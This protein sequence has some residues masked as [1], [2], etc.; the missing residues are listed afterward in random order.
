MYGFN[1]DSD[2]ARATPGGESESFSRNELM[3][4]SF[5]RVFPAAEGEMLLPFSR[6]TFE[7]VDFVLG[8]G[9]A[10]PESSSFQSGACT[11]RSEVLVEKDALDASGCEEE[12]RR[13]LHPSEIESPP[14][15]P[16]AS[17]TRLSHFSAC[18]ENPTEGHRGFVELGVAVGS[19]PLVL[20]GVPAL[21]PCSRSHSYELHD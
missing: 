16:L 10:L 8:V 3:K 6:T 4:G 19:C 1:H 21:F 18:S 11:E 14:S 20:P 7:R 17:V 2:I 9:C 12:T 13:E 15:D 5:H